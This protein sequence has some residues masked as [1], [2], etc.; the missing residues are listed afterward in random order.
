MLIVAA[1]IMIAATFAYAAGVQKMINDSCPCY[2]AP[3]NCPAA[4]RTSQWPLP[5]SISVWM[6][7]PL[8]ALLL[9]FGETSGFVTPSKYTKIP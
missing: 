2:D 3:V 4:Q 5:N 9:A 7:T 8:Y 6:K 1:L